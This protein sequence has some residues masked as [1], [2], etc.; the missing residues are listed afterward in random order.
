MFKEERKV[1]TVT[2]CVESNLCLVDKKNVLQFFVRV[3]AHVPHPFF[4]STYRF[5]VTLKIT[6]EA[7]I[8]D[9]RMN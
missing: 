7:E 3:L 5:I 6:D 1:R 2:V 8:P 4:R 9:K